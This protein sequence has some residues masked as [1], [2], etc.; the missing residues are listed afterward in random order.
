M[1]SKF[2]NS[3]Q[4]LYARAAFLRSGM[5]R[6]STT[7]QAH[8]RQSNWQYQIAPLLVAPLAYKVMLE[9]NQ[10][11][12][13]EPPRQDR[14]RGNYENKIRFF[15][16]PE[17]IFETFASVKTEDGKLVMS[18]SDFFRALTPYNHT[19]L[20]DNKKYF[21]KYTPE[22]LKVADSNNDGVISFPEFFFFITILQMPLG[23]IAKEFQK[24][25]QRMNKEKFSQV[26]TELRKKTILGQKQTNKGFVPDAR[27]ISAKEEDF[28]QTN[29]EVTE[30]LFAEKSY[31][32][33][34]DFMRFRD[35]LKTSL[36]HYE[37]HQYD[38]DDE[39]D[40]ISNEDFAKSLLVC[41]PHNQAQTYI[42]R[43][44]NLKLEGDC[45]FQEFIAF[46]RFID[47]VDNIKEK[48]LVYR[49]ITLDQLKQLGKEFC[50]QD[51]YC[52]KNK[53]VNLDNQIEAMVKLL[54]LDGN[55]QLD[56]DEVIGVLDQRQLLG[57]G[58]EHEI[59]EALENGVKKGFSWIRETLKI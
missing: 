12:C 27:L 8:Q 2:F 48:V 35:Q 40:T 50:E 46:Q 11:M 5:M 6:I 57:Q 30:H 58:K 59:K 7:Q 43:V 26:L 49:Y 44:H 52:K 56:H 54:D 16:P 41:L 25:G 34:E 14:I 15:S 23:L 38:V 42:K 21:E 22:V 20:K 28:L 10:G 9:Q 24:G 33:L 39:K 47:D 32:T 36:R 53:I 29:R 17:K 31:Y 3:F 4:R 18:Y 13:E 45:S 1:N 19:E 51:D 55:G 37:F